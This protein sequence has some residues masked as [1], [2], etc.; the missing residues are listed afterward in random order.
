MKP[1]KL[2]GTL[3]DPVYSSWAS[4]GAS[5]RISSGKLS[6]ESLRGLFREPCLLSSTVSQPKRGRSQ[7]GRKLRENLGALPEKFRSASIAATSEHHRILDSLLATSLLENR[8]EPTR[9]FSEQDTRRIPK[10]DK[11]RISIRSIPKQ[12]ES[13]GAV[14]SVLRNLEENPRKFLIQI[15]RRLWRGLLG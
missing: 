13:F 10:M 5:P 8:G 11:F 14:K 1:K 7:T 4:F 12:R 2:L 15:Q 9:P 3:S 6:R